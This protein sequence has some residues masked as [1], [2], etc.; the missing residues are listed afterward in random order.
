MKVATPE[1]IELV[2]RLCDDLTRDIKNLADK[3]WLKTAL[4]SHVTH[5]PKLVGEIVWPIVGIWFP[6]T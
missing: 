5:L 2:R 6:N 4:V 3:D 1:E